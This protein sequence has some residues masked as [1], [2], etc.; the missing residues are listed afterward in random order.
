MANGPAPGPP[1]QRLS[2]Q[3][4]RR[5]ASL[6]VP[7]WS[8]ETLHTF[9]KRSPSVSAFYSAPV[10]SFAF[11]SGPPSSRSAEPLL[12]VTGATVRGITVSPVPL[13]CKGFIFFWKKWL[14]WRCSSELRHHFTV[15]AFLTINS[16]W[17]QTCYVRDPGVLEINLIFLFYFLGFLYLILLSIYL[18]SK[19]GIN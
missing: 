6:P 12:I 17:K 19:S 1:R 7:I 8:T 13:Y 5:F 18:K 2:I 10:L 9:P 16:E 15:T 11:P 4:L 3:F 14:Q